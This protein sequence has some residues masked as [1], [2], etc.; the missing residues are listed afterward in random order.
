MLDHNIISQLINCL[1]ITGDQGVMMRIKVVIRSPNKTPYN[2]FIML[3]IMDN[4]CIT[5]L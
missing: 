3:P 1:L 4:M 2:Y 5:I